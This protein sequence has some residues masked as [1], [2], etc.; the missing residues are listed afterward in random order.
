MGWMKPS[1]EEDLVLFLKRG[2]GLGSIG[3]IHTHQVP[4]FLLFR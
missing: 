3:L 2:S 1:P 4:K